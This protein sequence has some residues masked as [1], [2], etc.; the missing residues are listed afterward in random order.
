VRSSLTFTKI[1]E[2]RAGSYVSLVDC[3][4]RSLVI[5][6]NEYRGYPGYGLRKQVIQ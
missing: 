5:R 4:P 3:R 2:L 6:G 1:K